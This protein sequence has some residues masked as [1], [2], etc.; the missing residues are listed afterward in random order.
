MTLN[1]LPIIRDFVTFLDTHLKSHTL[2]EAMKAVI[3]RSRSKVATHGYTPNIQQILKEK[4]CIIIANHPHDAE[5]VTILSALPNHRDDISLI[6]NYRMMGIVSELDRYCIPVYIEHHIDPIKRYPRIG[7]LIAL[8]NPKQLF[9]EKYEH[10]RNRESIDEV[11]KRIND[12]GMVLLFPGKRAGTNR[13]FSGV[14]HLTS[15]IKKNAGAYIIPIYVTGT[16][17]MDILRMIPFGG[18]I[19]PQIDM[20]FFEP[21]PVSSLLS[22]HPKE[23]TKKLQTDFEKNVQRLSGA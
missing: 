13:W 23:I 12:G 17:D 19:L 9:D 4:P 7:K 5:V 1:K 11:A 22:F 8:T 16:S 14:G 3:Q 2:P 18:R 6:I 21:I 20:T 10:Q 15:K